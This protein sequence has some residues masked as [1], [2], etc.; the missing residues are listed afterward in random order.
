MYL[1]NWYTYLTILICSFPLEQLCPITQSTM[2]FGLVH[3]NKPF[4]AGI[5][6]GA[7]RL[8]KGQLKVT[9]PDCIDNL[10]KA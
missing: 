9:F 1:S 2:V 7:M 6:N 10:V 8:S 5:E 3:E 4:I